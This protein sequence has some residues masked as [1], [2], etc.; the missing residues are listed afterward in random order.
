MPAANFVAVSPSD[1]GGRPKTAVFRTVVETITPERAIQLLEGNVHNR[2]LSQKRVTHYARLIR[3]GMFRLT[4][5]GVAIDWN[6]VLQDGQHRLWA[7]VETNTPVDMQ[8]SYDVDPANFDVIDVGKPRSGADVL[9]IA[10][11]EGNL[12]RVAAAARLVIGYRRQRR[13]QTRVTITQQEIV[14]LIQREPKLVEWVKIATGLR[15][16]KNWAT[17]LAALAHLVRRDYKGKVEQF[18]KEVNSG[19]NLSPGS[20]ALTLRDRILQ[21]QAGTTA[22]KRV[23]SSDDRFQQ[24]V[25]CWNSWVTGGLRHQIKPLPE[26][27]QIKGAE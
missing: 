14:D 25:Q 18:L 4:H 24:I 16:V 17:P 13:R 5:Q 12:T 10:G 21:T 7:I 22:A 6:G 9:H 8:V 11:F 26:T 3:Q 27:P 19:A 2:A 15:H 23:R 20:P 1:A